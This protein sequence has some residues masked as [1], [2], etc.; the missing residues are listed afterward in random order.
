V[1]ATLTALSG[2]LFKWLTL[3]LV[4]LAIMVHLHSGQLDCFLRNGFF[5]MFSLI[6]GH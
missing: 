4:T 2:I 1:C 5:H 6:C 3:V